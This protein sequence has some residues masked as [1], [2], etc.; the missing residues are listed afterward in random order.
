MKIHF[1][2]TAILIAAGC[3]KSDDASRRSDTSV[4]P[5]VSLLPDSAPAAEKNCGITG[6]PVLT[7]EGIGELKEG[8][9]VDDVRAR[10][11]V[12]SDSEQ[13]GSEGMKERV[14]VVRVG[15]ETVRAT[16]NDDRIYRIEVSTPRLATTDSLAVD[17]P[18]HMIA[19][20]RGAKFL[21]GEDGVYGFIANHC[22]MSF[23]FSVPLRPP[24][25]GDWTAARIDS[26]HGDAVVD[27]ILI[28]KCR[29]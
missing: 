5:P 14:L 22:A 29:P 11:E 10:C 9:G 20:A 2:L 12:I 4:A 17:T 7:D 3:R 25:G 28:T 8:L 16:V 18:L 6:V 19:A 23:R 1:A 15:G 27:R 26:A 24:R 21:P 13:Q